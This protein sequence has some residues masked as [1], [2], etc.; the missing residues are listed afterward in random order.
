MFQLTKKEFQILRSQNATSS[1]GGR[2][3]M[4]LTLFTI[5]MILLASCAG[6]LTEKEKRTVYVADEHIVYQNTIYEEMPALLTLLKCDESVN[7]FISPLIN[8]TK[9][10]FSEAIADFLRM[11]GKPKNITITI[12]D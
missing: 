4:P 7:I 10:R 12:M 8:T 3:T 11:C 6:G 2:R 1:W 5:V 9:E